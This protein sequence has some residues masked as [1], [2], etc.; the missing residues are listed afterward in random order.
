VVMNQPAAALATSRELNSSLEKHWRNA[1]KAINS[2]SRD[3]ND[4]G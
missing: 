2:G 3:D 1:V 4:N